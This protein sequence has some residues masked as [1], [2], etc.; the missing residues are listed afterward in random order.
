MCSAFWFTG[1]LGLAQHDDFWD[2]IAQNVQI[3]RQDITSLTSNSIILDDGTSILADALLCGTGWKS[4][5]PFFS[6]SLAESL[7]L[8]HPVPEAASSN[9]ESELWESLL[10]QADNLVL[11]RFPQLAHPPPHHRRPS[12]TTTAKLYNGIAPLDSNHTSSIVFLGHVD[13]SNSFR[14]A[15]AQAIWSTAYLSGHMTLPA[16][17]EMQQRVAYMNAFSRRR[18]PSHGQTG[19]CIFFELIWY[20]DYLLAEVGLKSHRPRWWTRAYWVEPCLARDFAGVREEYRRKFGL[21]RG[22]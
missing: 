10:T 3:H 12:P 15:E 14:A 11:S 13:I 4:N 8:P 7:G 20:T 1:P 22:S 9:S 5:Y 6:P 18:Y 16:L 2:T 19:S 17:A 21:G